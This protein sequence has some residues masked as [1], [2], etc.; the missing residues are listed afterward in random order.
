MGKASIIYVMG[1]TVMLGYALMN[2]SSSSTM[3]LDN[4][5]AYYGRS[6]AHNLAITGA[7]IG[8]QL[9]MRDAN[10]TGDLLNQQYAGGSYDLYFERPGGDSIWVRC[11]SKIDVSAE[12]LRDTVIACLRFTSFGK[13]GWFTDAE[14]NGYSG[15]PYFG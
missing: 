7:N 3:S 2:I 10:Y 5:T 11:Y 4:F 15:C 9:V 1:L 6:M 12:T 13:Y 8:A 14:K